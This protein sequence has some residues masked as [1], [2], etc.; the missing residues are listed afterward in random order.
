MDHDIEDFVGVMMP[1]L[2]EK[3]QR[4]FLG[5]LSK[6]LGQGSAT[7]LSEITGIT[8]Q[9]ITQ[10]RKD[11]EA[12]DRDPRAEPASQGRSRAPG[13]GRKKLIEKDPGIVDEILK[14]L[15]GNVLGD[16]ESL[17]TWTVKSTTTL[18]QEL[19]SKGKN[20][21]RTT[22]GEILK[23]EGFSL[24]QNRKYTERGEAGPDR[25]RQ[26]SFIKEQSALHGMFGHP[27]ISVDAKKKEL[28]G[29]YK[30]GGSEYRPKGEPRLV[31]DHDFMG[32]EGKAT[33]YG[34]YD[35]HGNE[36]YVSVGISAD[37]AEFAVNSIGFWWELMGKERYPDATEVMITADCGGSNGRRN[38]L[39]K[40]KLQELADDTGLTFHVRHYPPGTSKWNK[41]EHRMFSYISMNW[42]GQPLT[43]LETIVSLIGS[44][45]T[46]KG[47][48]VLCKADE[49]IYEKGIRVSD[50]DFDRINLTP[51][52]WKPEW[53]Y[54]ISP[55][56]R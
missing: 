9:T 16:P 51:G 53:N 46:D 48:S 5:G 25:D 26:F 56:N 4:L 12:A 55:R 22:V 15:D 24:Q 2:N 39:W 34:V 44:T 6:M 23:A 49:R 14:L 47:L 54:T 31:N 3:Q 1:L 18:S 45:R 11:Y 19:A 21:S 7:E 33:P 50:E 40:L 32:P 36:G 43:S 27:V 38:R 52:E 17:L 20:V 8:K 42:K 30:N 28:I 41:I 13:G 10:G 35:I 37:T 29:N